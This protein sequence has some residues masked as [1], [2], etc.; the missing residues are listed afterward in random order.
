MKAV[1]S[2]IKQFHAKFPGFLAKLAVDRVQREKDQIG[3][4]GD[5]D[6]EEV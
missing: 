2:K 3:E 6:V 1:N 4:W 5:S